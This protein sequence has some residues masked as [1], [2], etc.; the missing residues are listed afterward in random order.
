ME[1]T[2]EGRERKI[3]QGNSFKDVRQGNYLYD[4]LGMITF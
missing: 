4:E 1:E 3:P 2:E